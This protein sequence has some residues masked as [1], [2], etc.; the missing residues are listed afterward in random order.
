MSMMQCGGIKIAVLYP[1]IM[2]SLSH[3]V[4]SG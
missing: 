1:F 3:S 2:V 4:N